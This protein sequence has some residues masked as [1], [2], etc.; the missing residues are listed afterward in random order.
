MNSQRNGWRASLQHRTFGV[1][2]T[3][4]AGL[5]LAGTLAAPAAA[6]SIPEGD[7]HL[8]VAFP[9]GSGSDVLVRFLAEKLRPVSGRTVVVENKPGAAGN[10]ATQYMTRSK[11]NG[12]TI[13][14]HPA[15]TLASN[16]HLIKNNPVN[17]VKDVQVAATI[18]KQTVM[19]VVDAKRPWKTMGDLTA[20][21]RKVG[22]KGTYATAGSSSVIMCALYKDAAKL[23][24]VEVNYKTAPDSL[25][26]M[27]SGVIDFACHDPLF[28]LTHQREG[29]FR[30]LG[31]A[32]G[33]RL[34]AAPDLPTMT[35]A[36]Y[37]MDLSGWFA[38]MVPAGTPKSIVQQVNSWF[39][40]ITSQEDTKRFLQNSGSDVWVTT[41]EEGQAQLAKDIE[42]W[43]K[44]VS[45]AK[46][47][48]Q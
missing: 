12:L 22:D 48:P 1:A 29:R 36:G 13:F 47:L 28:A 8:V 40:E 15:N 23:E 45:I 20:H 10:I 42:D 37:P 31:V 24:S 14:V 11:P 25:N 18:N 21:L 19:L 33:E 4:A 2:L 44:Y 6:Q 38:A 5:M 17:A 7:I 43:G 3:I 41:P 9:P 26:D 27:A 34:T 35:E 30:I 32:T 46:L 16:F 39:G